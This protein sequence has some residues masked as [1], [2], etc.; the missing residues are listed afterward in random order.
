MT[1][2]AGRQNDGDLQQALQ[3][4]F[5]PEVALSDPDRAVAALQLLSIAANAH[6]SLLVALVYPTCLSLSAAAADGSTLQISSAP[7]TSSAQ[8]C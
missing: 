4:P 3:D 7:Q 2:L 5:K 8:V 6:P 1:A